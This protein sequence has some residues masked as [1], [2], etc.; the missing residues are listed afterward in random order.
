MKLVSLYVY[1]VKSLRGIQVGAAEVGDRGFVG[2]RRMMIVDQNG[3]FL[4]QRV[5]PR[6]ALVTTALEGDALRLS[7]PGCAPLVIAARPE[8][9][10]ARRVVVWDDVCD[11]ISLGR[12]AASWLGSFLETRCELVY[13]PDSTLR[14]VDPERAPPDTPVSFADGFPFLLATSASLGELNRRGAGGVEM[15]RFRPNLVVDGDVPFDE[16]RWA[17]VEIGTVRFRVV[18]PCARCSIT[19]VDPRSG[20]VG[21]EPLATLA[22]F[23][24]FDGKVMFGQNLIAEGRGIVRVGDPC[25]VTHTGP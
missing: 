15:E 5:L 12:E 16:D 25:R 22:T 11:A 24:R 4:T 6:M 2:D 23:R 19:T 18:K 9:G 20:A 21:K 13:M 3:Q 7:A 1:P 8:T 17:A 14:P 10:E